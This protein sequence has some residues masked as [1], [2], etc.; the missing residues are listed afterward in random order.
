MLVSFRTAEFY[1]PGQGGNVQFVG[2]GLGLPPLGP[3]FSAGWPPTATQLF[4][5]S[6]QYVPLGQFGFCQLASRLTWVPDMVHVGAEVSVPEVWPGLTL[7]SSICP[8]FWGAIAGLPLEPTFIVTLL[9]CAP[10]AV[11]V[12]V[13]VGGTP[14]GPAL[15]GIGFSAAALPAIR[16]KAT[17]LANRDA[18]M[19]MVF[20]LSC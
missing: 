8:G 3:V 10:G 17:A 2:P 1:S 13:E 19:R 4:A 16:A 15:L 11:H 18:C 5:G 7:R 20:L 9:G 6:Y 12:G 14:D